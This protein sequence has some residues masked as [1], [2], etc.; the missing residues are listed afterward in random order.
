MVI[1]WVK[2]MDMEFELIGTSP[3]VANA[4]RRILIAEVPTMAIEHVFLVNN[5]SIIAVRHSLLACALHK[6]CRTLMRTLGRVSEDSTPEQPLLHLR[7]SLSAAAI[8]ARCLYM[9]ALLTVAFP[10]AQDEVLSHR[11][12][13]VPIR[14]DPD[15]F[16]SKAGQSA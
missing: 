5:T 15:L 3:A 1:N 8:L 11:L 9:L 4:L 10:T 7:T 14:A 12:G 16:E 2:G 6:L 13:L